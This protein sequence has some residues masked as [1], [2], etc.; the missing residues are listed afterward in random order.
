MLSHR[1]GMVS[2]PLQ[3]RQICFYNTHWTDLDNRVS[4]LGETPGEGRL[5]RVLMRHPPPAICQNLWGGGGG[6]G[7]V[8]P[9]VRGGGSSRGSGGV[10]LGVGRGGGVAYKDRARPPP[11]G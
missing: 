9:G 7:G 1:L 6:G 8:Q 5:Q 4:N 10:Q 2:V 3:M 11:G